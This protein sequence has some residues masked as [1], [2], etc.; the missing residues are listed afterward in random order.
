MSLSQQIVDNFDKINTHFNL[1]FRE[2]PK[3]FIGRCPIHDGDNSTA[4]TIY[5]SGYE[6]VGVWRCFTGDCHRK[7]GGNAIGFIR[8][9]LSRKYRKNVEFS[10]AI[11]WC[12]EFFGNKITITQKTDNEHLT[13]LINRLNV[14]PPEPL[15]KLKP[16]EFIS[17]L[18]IP[19]YYLDKGYSK[20]TL[21]KFHVGFCNNPAKPMYNRCIV[22][23]FDNKGEFIIGAMGRS[24]FDK[25]ETCGNHHDPASFCRKF[26]KWWNTPSFPSEHTFYNFSQAKKFINDT[27]LAILI[28]GCGHTWRIDEAEFPMALGTF[29]SKFS[30][31]QK[32][33]LDTTAATTLVVVPDAGKAGQILVEHVKERCRFTH[34]IVII[35]PSYKDDIG[36]CN[37]ETVK[38]IL[39]PIVDKYNGN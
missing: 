12:E 28:E 21:E 11:K 2:T 35:E 4:V 39:G 20:K 30:D 25:C 15:F 27:G 34:N 10:D 37:I 1:D 19:Q 23:Q 7:Y 29:G 31:M 14:E 33:L 17:K 3:A 26:T 9:L 13:S 18:S 32:K 8:G 38:R 24:I 36:A 16:E 22:P 6:T 5:T